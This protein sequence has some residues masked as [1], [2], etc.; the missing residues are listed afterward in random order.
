MKHSRDF[1][2]GKQLKT[3]TVLNCEA[4][5]TFGAICGKLNEKLP[6]P[7]N[8]F[9]GG[10]EQDQLSE[11][12]DDERTPT[13]YATQ[14]KQ[15]QIPTGTRQRHP[16]PYNS[17]HER[18]ERSAEPARITELEE[19]TR[20]LEMAMDKILTRLIPDD[21]LIP[22]LNRDSQPIV[23]VATR[24][25]SALSNV[26]VPTK[27]RGSGRLN[28]EPSSSKRNEEL[29]KKN[30]DL[31]RQLKDVQKS[32]D[33]LKSPRDYMQRFNKATL[34]ID[35]VPDTICLSALLHG[36]K[37]GRFLN[38]LLENPPKSWNE[39]QHWVKRPTPQTHDSSRADKIKY[40]DYHHG[41]GH[42]TEDCQSLKDELEF[43]ARN[44]KL[45]GRVNI[46]PSRTEHTRDA[47][48]MGGQSTRGRKAYARQV[49]TVNKNR[50]LKRPFKETEWENAPITFSST[51]YKRADGEP[52]IMMPHANPFV[53][54]VHI[55][56]HNVNKVFIDTG[57]SPVS[58]WSCF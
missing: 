17:Q 12:D 53:A 4:A 30:A 49:M 11:T 13:E 43:L 21:P 32:I 10:A 50:P 33:E 45:E 38:N 8:L 48:S 26:V 24:N 15:F 54:T 9:V 41:Y 56:N 20:V 3:S 7:R 52:D 39:I 51:D 5:Q 18:P 1:Q 42:N 6:M 57:S 44:G 22:L 55:G 40:C 46:R 34:D 14:P 31:E 27:P 58:F 29:L 19:R 16:R 47:Y 37:R 2:V 28:P 36:L 23:V 35:N 25:S